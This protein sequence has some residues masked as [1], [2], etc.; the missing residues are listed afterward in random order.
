[1]STI[2]MR[3]V[4]RVRRVW[5]F[6]AIAALVAIVTVLALA[7]SSG[8]SSGSVVSVHQPPAQRQYIGG[9]AEFRAQQAENVAR[10]T[11]EPLGQRPGPRP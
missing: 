2:A 5:A 6:A 8:G 9:H 10:T 11:V 3:P 7:L 4:T 1:V